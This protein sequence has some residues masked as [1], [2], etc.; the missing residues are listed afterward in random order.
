MEQDCGG[1]GIALM[2]IGEQM[3]R[4]NDSLVDNWVLW[5]DQELVGAQG[6]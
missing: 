3:I 1:I 2:V 4:P 5:M 6:S